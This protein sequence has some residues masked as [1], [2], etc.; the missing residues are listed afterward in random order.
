MVGLWATIEIA[1]DQQGNVL[2]QATKYHLLS[3][4]ENAFLLTR[5]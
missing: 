1:F 5:S 4:D 3:I 2:Q